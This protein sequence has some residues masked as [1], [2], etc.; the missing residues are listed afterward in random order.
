MT[1]L[2]VSCV[3]PVFNGERYLT[4]ALDSITAQS[5]KAVEI[6]VVDDG[7]TDRTAEIA[8]RH[9][10]GVRYFVQD[11]AGPATARNLGIREARGACIAFLD[12]DDRWP[13]EK[14]DRQLRVL[15]ERPG[16]GAVVGHATMFRDDGNTT[17]SGGRPTDVPIP[18]YIT[19]SLLATRETFD[20]VGLFETALSHAD[21]TAWF[22]RARALGV[23]IVLLPDVLLQLRLHGSNMSQ[24]RRGESFDEYLRLI[25]ATLD[26]R[27]RSGSL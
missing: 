4:E 25:K 24:A 14:L 9:P 23:D 27:R 18:A 12:A 26:Q 3:I 2:L 20:R 19:G 16:T 1:P 6:I 15:H 21:D 5:H 8:R 22:L 17:D 13:P 11:N 10:A 7:S